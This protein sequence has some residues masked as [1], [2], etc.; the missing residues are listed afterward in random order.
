[1]PEA[2][3]MR[4]GKSWHKAR[5]QDETKVWAFVVWPVAAT[6]Y[7]TIPFTILAIFDNICRTRPISLI[8]M[9]FNLI[10]RQC[11]NCWNMIM[12]MTMMSS[13]YDDT[14]LLEETLKPSRSNKIV[15]TYGNF[16][17]MSEILL[18]NLKCLDMN[19]ERSP[20]TQKWCSEFCTNHSKR[21]GLLLL[22]FDNVLS[23]FPLPIHLNMGSCGLIKRFCSLNYKNTAL[24]FWEKI[25]SNLDCFDTVR[26]VL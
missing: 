5:P 4:I 23:F 14:T 6:K 20:Y 24:S 26:S 22:F 3:I 11:C 1:M 18:L 12:I 21:I 19:F 17:K 15:S 25:N 7:L 8:Q 2:D 10:I 13:K 16:S 9:W